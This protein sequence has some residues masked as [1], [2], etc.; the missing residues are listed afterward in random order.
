MAEGW[1]SFLG[2]FEVR[3]LLDESLSCECLFLES[4]FAWVSVDKSI[5]LFV[6][7]F[8]LS[9]SSVLLCLMWFFFFWMWYVALWVCFWRVFFMWITV[10]NSKS[11]FVG[12][13]FLYY[14]NVLVYFLTR[15]SCV[16]HMV[17]GC[18]HMSF[19]KQ[20]HISLY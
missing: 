12:L 5:P 8:F 18:V 16:L 1:V 19:D 20:V 2:F 15:F 7:F 6:E 14:I 9:Y 10:D 17:Y 13:L 11:L 3:R 4:F